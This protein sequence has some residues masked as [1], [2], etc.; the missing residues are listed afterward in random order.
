MF[1]SSSHGQKVAVII[2][3]GQRGVTERF[4]VN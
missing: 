1:P 3:I 2:V 4:E